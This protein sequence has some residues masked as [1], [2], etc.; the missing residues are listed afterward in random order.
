VGD[1][2]LRTIAV[3]VD[4]DETDALLGVVANRRGA[5]DHTPVR[6]QM[7]ASLSEDEGREPEAVAPRLKR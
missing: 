1:G 4:I 3:T 7:L 5:G 6:L 2:P